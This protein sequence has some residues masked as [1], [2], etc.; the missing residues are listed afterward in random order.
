MLA[1]YR[2]DEI[3]VSPSRK[4][5]E[6]LEAHLRQLPQVEIKTEHKFVP[7]LYIR[8]VT[9]PADTYIVGEACK[10]EHLSVMVRGHMVA[11]ADGAMRVLKGYNEWLAPAGVKRAGTAIEETVWFTVHPNPTDERDINKLE[12]MLFENASTLQRRLIADGLL[13]TEAVCPQLQ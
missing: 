2:P 5:V 3:V 12:E 10:F 8:Q 11:L 6:R 7:G 4:S 1:E 13:T 9:F